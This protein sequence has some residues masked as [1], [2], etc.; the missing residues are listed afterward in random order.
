MSGQWQCGHALR[1][2]VVDD[3]PDTAQS[4]AEIL[5]DFGYDVR[6]ALGG[7]DAVRMA[8]AAWPDVV[9][10]DLAM[11]GVD[12]CEVARRLRAQRG[13][14]KVFI[15]A[16]TGLTAADGRRSADAAGVHVYF[17]KPTN[18]D[19]LLAILSHY[20]ELRAETEALL[21]VD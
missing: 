4:V 7:S 6:F 1:V 17:K 2:L 12:G 3:H 9:L 20:R 5:A 19:L 8:A 13:G 15:I 10:L 11:P 14:R 16:M 21:L 18:L